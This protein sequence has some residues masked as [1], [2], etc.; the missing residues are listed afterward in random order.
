MQCAGLGQLPARP[1]PADLLG[2]GEAECL[3]VG[4][5]ARLLQ[6]LDVALDQVPAGHPLPGH[7]RSAAEQQGQQS[8]TEAERGRERSLARHGGSGGGSAARRD[9]RATSKAPP[10]EVHAWHLKQAGL[11]PDTGAGARARQH[12]A[13]M[14]LAVRSPRLGRGLGD[15]G[16]VREERLGDGDVGIEAVAAEIHHLAGSAGR[17]G[18][19]G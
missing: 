3:V 17:Q 7:L 15:A 5:A 12:R 10:H 9:V 8:G 4:G 2:V 1:G 19:D 18:G 6:H 13:C 16:E 11:G 14:T